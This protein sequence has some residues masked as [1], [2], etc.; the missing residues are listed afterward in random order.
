MKKTRKLTALLAALCLLVTLWVPLTVTAETPRPVTAPA[1]QATATDPMLATAELLGAMPNGAAL[2]Y[3]YLNIMECIMAGDW[4]VDL[5]FGTYSITEEEATWVE[6][7]V[8]ASVPEG[9]GAD[10]GHSYGFVLWEKDGICFYSSFYDWGLTEE[11]E[12]ATNAAVKQMTR[13]LDGK[14]DFE[15]SVILYERLIDRNHYDFSGNYHQTAYGALIEEKS[16]CAGYARAYQLLLQEVGIPCLYIFGEAYN[17]YQTGGH[18][19]NLVL[20]DG[21]WYY[22]DPTW[23]DSD[24]A[25]L[26]LSYLYFNIT[27]AE[28]STDHYAD[29][30]CEPWLPTEPAIDANYY[31]HEG[32]LCN[33]PTVEL[34]TE[35]F[36]RQNPV[37]LYVTE[38]RDAVANFFFQ[39]AYEI[40]AQLG[41]TDVDFVTYSTAGNCGLLLSFSRSATPGDVNGDG[42]VNNRDLALLQQYINGWEV[43]IDV[44]VAD[45]ND[46]GDV[47]NRD[48]ALLQQYINGWDVILK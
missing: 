9:Y 40:L 23:D 13:D 30:T 42:D 33:N 36:R 46:D 15:K 39:Y 11:M 1:A 18:A 43:T 34:L 2:R 28:I 44:T 47:N 5:P 25:D 21:K 3:F 7:A 31:V 14:S 22:S 6:A 48:L 12:Q 10:V 26:P 37:I 19:W 16:V 35:L 24:N 4:S 8:N 45:V 41:W 38:D 32:T 27:Y 29:Y 17:G 20:L